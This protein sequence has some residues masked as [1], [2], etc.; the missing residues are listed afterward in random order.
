MNHVRPL[1]TGNGICQHYPLCLSAT[2]RT[3]FVTR[4]QLNGLDIYFRETQLG[5]GHLTSLFILGQTLLKYALEKLLIKELMSWSLFER[6][7]IME[8]D[9]EEL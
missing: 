9:D 6:G 7:F 5:T 1:L 4:R 3:S 8:S 2:S